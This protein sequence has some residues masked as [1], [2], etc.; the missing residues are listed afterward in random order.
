MKNEL[1]LVF[2]DKF[3]I[4]LMVITRSCMKSCSIRINISSRYGKTLIIR[5]CSYES[6]TSIHY[7]IGNKTHAFNYR[8]NKYNGI[9]RLEINNYF[10]EILFLKKS[11]ENFHVTLVRI[12]YRLFFVCVHIRLNIEYIQH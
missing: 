4:Q 12:I 11:V 3:K 9:I 1:N 10:S 7:K 5:N 2:R 6:L 8:F